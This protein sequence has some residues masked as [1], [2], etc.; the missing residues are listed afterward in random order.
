MAKPHCI[1]ST[2]FVIFL[3]L[4]TVVLLDAQEGEIVD[5]LKIQGN[6]RVDDSTIFFYLK[7]K[8]GE[9]LSKKKVREDIQKIY[10]LG[11]FK[12]IRV[13][14]QRTVKGLEVIFMVEE[15]PSVGGI[16]ISGNKVIDTSKLMEKIG[17]DRGA[18][19]NESMI[20]QITQKITQEYHNKG[21]FYVRVQVD[22]SIS[23]DNQVIMVISVLSLRME[24]THYCF[25]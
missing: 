10:D 11:Q 18:T 3:L 2:F 24:L 14:T 1:Y 25:L 17:I 23:K 16:N 22:S 9:P 21:Y 8:I 5:T 7:T 6:K 19:F 13:E 15:K 4:S 20:K 12:D